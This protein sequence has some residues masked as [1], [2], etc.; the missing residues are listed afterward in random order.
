[1]ATTTTGTAATM[2]TVKT[3][4]EWA[5]PVEDWAAG[6]SHPH[7]AGVAR[8][9]ARSAWNARQV[10]IDAL[11]GEYEVI[12][13]QFRGFRTD[14]NIFSHWMRSAD[15]H[16]CAFIHAR[17]QRLFNDLI[18]SRAVAKALGHENHKLARRITGQRIAIRKL[19]ALLAGGGV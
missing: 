5:G 18:K 8:E 6:S 9:A 13:Q 12:L 17:N 3:F 10:E 11:R 19:R 4:D 15:Q 7:L 1:M 16:D 2:A 14:Q